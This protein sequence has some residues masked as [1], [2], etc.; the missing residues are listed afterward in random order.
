MGFGLFDAFRRTSARNEFGHWSSSLGCK[1]VP[2]CKIGRRAN[3]QQKKPCLCAKSAGQGDLY[4]N[5]T[6]LIIHSLD[7]FAQLI[8]FSRLKALPSP[9]CAQMMTIFL[10]VMIWLIT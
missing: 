9:I 2:T 3:W 6:A 10:G 8:L 4:W 1:P 5:S 7:L